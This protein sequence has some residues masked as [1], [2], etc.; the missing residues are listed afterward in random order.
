MKTVA[1]IVYVNRESFVSKE[2]HAFPIRLAP[3]D[4]RAHVEIIDKYSSWFA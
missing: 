1:I 4:G 2:K 3:S